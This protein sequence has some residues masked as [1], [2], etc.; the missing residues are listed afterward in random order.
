[1]LKAIGL[2]KLFYFMSSIAIHVRILLK[3]D[4]IYFTA[5]KFLKSVAHRQ[6]A[7]KYFLT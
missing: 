6:M 3:K 1:M 4:V 5:S 7:L 2:S